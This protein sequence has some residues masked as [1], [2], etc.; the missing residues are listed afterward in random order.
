MITTQYKSAANRTNGVICRVCDD[1]K[2]EK[3]TQELYIVT[4]K[5]QRLIR[6]VGMSKVF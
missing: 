2:V 1:L 5:Q 6:Y 4:T 3:C